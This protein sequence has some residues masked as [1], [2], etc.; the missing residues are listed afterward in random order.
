MSGHLLPTQWLLCTHLSRQPLPGAGLGSWGQ[1]WLAILSSPTPREQ[2]LL[3]TGRENRHLPSRPVSRTLGWAQVLPALE[4][5]EP[6]S[7]QTWRPHL[8]PTLLCPTPDK[9]DLGPSCH[10]P[11]KSDQSQASS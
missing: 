11:H 8:L 7:T 1:V 3:E 4:G 2:A 10:Q 9:N 6:S 5:V